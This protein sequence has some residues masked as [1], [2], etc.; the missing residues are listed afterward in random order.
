M[1][2]RGHNAA[3]PFA[4]K[5]EGIKKWAGKKEKKKKESRTVINGGSREHSAVSIGATPFP[6]SSFA[7]WRRH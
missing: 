7:F 5:V 1:R 6:P 2:D 3:S 4:I